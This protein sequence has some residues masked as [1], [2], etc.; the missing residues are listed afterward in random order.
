MWLHI[1][2]WQWAGSASS[3]PGQLLWVQHAWEWSVLFEGA[4][5]GRFPHLLCKGHNLTPKTK[6]C[7][8]SLRGLEMLGFRFVFEFALC[9]KN[10]TSIEGKT[11]P[12]SLKL[13]WLAA[14]LRMT[15]AQSIPD[16]E[17]PAVAHTHTQLLSSAASQTTT[18]SG[19]W[20]H[21]RDITN[22]PTRSPWT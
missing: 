5:G 1:I 9:F 11:H 12:C 8:V 7:E 19:D 22:S 2:P 15:V 14:Q 17:F 18:D 20:Q 4:R 10:P 6:E 16:A 13:F 21:E 3:L